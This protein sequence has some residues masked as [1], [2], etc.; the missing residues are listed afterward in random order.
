MVVLKREAINQ[1]KA[2]LK[3]I[4]RRIDYDK[5]IIEIQKHIYKDD[6][7]WGPFRNLISLIKGVEGVNDVSYKDS[8]RY[9]QGY[10]WDRSISK[11]PI[12]K[13]RDIEIETDF[14]NL[15][16][17]VICSG[18]GTID[19]PLDSYDMILQVWVPSK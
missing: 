1:D 4:K 3:R 10:K 6:G 2:E 15:E 18:A 7:A 9:P 17:S 8:D 11:M 12:A 13:E 5:N 19:D 16:G 14:G